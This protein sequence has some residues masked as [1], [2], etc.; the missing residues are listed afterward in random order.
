MHMLQAIE[1]AMN[2]ENITKMELLS[3]ESR[4]EWEDPLTKLISGSPTK[5]LI[6]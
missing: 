4:R 5:R 3:L 2:A 1:K 6:N